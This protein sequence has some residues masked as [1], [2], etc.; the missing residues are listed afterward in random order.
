MKNKNII[1]LI[2]AI[3]SVFFIAGCSGKNNFGPYGSTHTHIDFKVY[4]LE[5]QIRFDLPKYTVM[6]DSAHVENN[7]GGVIHVH[8]TGMTLG[9]FFKSLGFGL[10]DDCFTLDS[11]N[12]YCNL[13]KATLK[14]YLK[15]QGSGWDLLYSPS[16]YIL[17]DLDKILV[18][19]GSDGSEEIKR[20]QASVTDK[21]KNT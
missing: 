1:I 10:T 14:V 20:Q 3:I 13:G 12:Q 2:L 6:E 17:Q 15:N 5:N 9:Y 7:D 18:S 19:Y 11:G 8:V 21:A 4:I 16:D